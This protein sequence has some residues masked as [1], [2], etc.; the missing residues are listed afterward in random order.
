MED[1]MPKD[2]YDFPLLSKFLSL[3]AGAP[4]MKVIDPNDVQDWDEPL[5][6]DP[7]YTA[8]HVFS[9][10]DVT[11]TFDGL[12]QG[13]VGDGET[14]VVD[15][16]AEP[17]TTKDGVDL[18]PVNSEFGYVVTDFG[19]AVAKTFEGNP[20]YE[21][22]LVGDLTDGEGNQIGL[23]VS[24]SETDTFKTPA[25]MGTWLSGLGGNTVK[26]STEHY[27]VMQAIL[28]DQ[29][30]PGD[31]EAEYPLDDDLYVVGG[32]YDG[33]R[34]EDAITLEGDSNGDGVANI[35]DVLAPNENS[36][37]EAIAVSSDYS[38]TLK[39]DGK[40]LF[41]WGNT[42]KK[43]NDVRIEA[44]IPLP[45]EWAVEDQESG[46]MPLYVVTEAEL[47]VHHTIT[48]NPN[49]QIRPEDYENEAATGTLPSYDELPDGTWVTTEAFYAGDGTLYP[50]GT[51]L[52]DPALADML[53]GTL[54]ADMGVVSADLVEGYTN[55]YY[56]ILDREPFEGVIDENGDYVVGP[57]WRLQSDKYGQDLP[58]V[59]IPEDP[60]DEPPVQNGEEKYEVGA[61]TQTVINL[62]DWDGIS[63]LTTSAGWQHNSDT[64]TANGVN[65]T[66]NFDVAFYIKGDIK[67]TTLYSTTLVMSYEEVDIADLGAG[68]IGTDGDDVLAGQG[69]NAFTGG[70]G[71]DLFVLSYGAESGAEV[72]ASSIGDFEVGTDM[73]AL[74]GFGITPPNDEDPF[75]PD[76]ITQVVV[77]GSLVLS[78]DGHELVT[79]VGITEEL[80]ADSFQILNP[81]ASVDPGAIIGT[82]GDDDLVGTAGDD[83]IIALDGNDT[84]AGLAGA[85]LLDGGAGIDTITFDGSAA[86]TVDLAT[87]TG[88]GGDAEGDTYFGIE[89]VVG[90]VFG[91]DITGNSAT[92]VISG[93]AGGD[94]LTGGAG[95]DVLIGGNGA[96][97]F[98]F[99][100]AGWGTDIILDFEDGV[101]LVSLEG[102]DVSP[103]DLVQVNIGGGVW[104]ADLDAEDPTGIFLFG[105]T[106]AQ[107]DGT[108][109][110]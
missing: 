93:R 80:S 97:L 68:V 24:N 54:L 3:R 34:L 5:N 74:Y 91:D 102:S 56:T 25:T 19:D 105:V 66:Q 6:D 13:D 59:V 38:V 64:V 36:I 11:G 94:T 23:V 22:G 100:D 14:P 51:V 103:S 107:I 48:N 83:T 86:V 108:D 84:L 63:P 58:S 73:I 42:I 101:D 16:D 29:R 89:N 78:L 95:N 62:L 15:F 41:R 46:L 70:L 1:V 60:T 96:D 81:S 18:Y 69:D 26:A 28:S 75:V 49:D 43:P 10:D 45:S 106:S 99:D 61:E 92:N 55:A 79:L 65:L 30:Y 82:D 40:L 50:A 9:T 109:F 67:P 8:T 52:K 76:E 7:T 21:E 87:G 85:D 44:E 71:A 31:P 27:V 53:E 12:T 33:M 4:V 57:R 47:V 110:V 90:T 35:R 37:T 2:L 72:V 88:S 17:T 77:D 39:D 20:E 104:L 98:V 32:P